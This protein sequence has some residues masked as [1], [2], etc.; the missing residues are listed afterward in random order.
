M[1]FHPNWISFFVTVCINKTLFL[2][3]KCIS[4]LYNYFVNFT[5]IKFLCV[6]YLFYICHTIITSS[7][8]FPLIIL[9]KIILPTW[10]FNRIFIYYKYINGR[11]FNWIGHFI[12]ELSLIIVKC[13]IHHNLPKSLLFFYLSSYLHIL[14]M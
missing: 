3:F 8:Q 7:I 5:I 1:K 6:L 13:T 2:F 12:T 14:C 11:N 4:L 9:F 10:N